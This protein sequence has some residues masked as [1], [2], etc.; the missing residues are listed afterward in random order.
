LFDRT[1][2]KPGLD[3]VGKRENKP[4]VP[5]HDAD[6]NENIVVTVVNAYAPRRRHGHEL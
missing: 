2:E 3:K 5:D 1:D 6:S 4:K